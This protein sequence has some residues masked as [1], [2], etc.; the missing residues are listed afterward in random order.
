MSTAERDLAV[1]TVADA[2]RVARAV[3]QDLA[4]VQEVLK[5]DRSPVTVA[6]FAVQAV[7][8]LALAEHDPKTPVVGEEDSG[9]LRGQENLPV[10][11]QVLA[12]V[13][14]VRPGVRIDEVLAAIDRGDHDGS[15]DRYWTLDPVDGTKGFLRNQQYAI[16]LAL[17]EKGR[18]TIGVLG[19]P[20]LPVD[21]DAPLDAPDAGGSMYAATAGGGCVEYAGCDPDATPTP[22]G[23]ASTGRPGP[24]SKDPLLGSSDP[25]AGGGSGGGGGSIDNHA[26]PTKPQPESGTALR[27]CESVEKAHSNQSDSA[28]VISALG[29]DPAP[30]RLDSQCKY[31]VVARGQADVYL[32]LPTK[33]GYVEKIWDHAAGMLVATEAG[34]R[35]SDISGAA[36][37][38]THGTRLEANRGVVCSRADVHAD[39]V[40]AIDRLGVGVPG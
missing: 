8:C 38:F 25:I 35:V 30:V 5:D 22:I 15:G 14:R 19:C 18:P 20:N 17:I 10:L 3:Q 2:C 37:D 6:D 29:A 27:V 23:S 40:G 34:A 33:P 21:H 24:T 7:V 36:L 9:A 13:R 4:N 11:E 16:A 12:A 32:R 39:I 31:A 26:P 28:R 1:R